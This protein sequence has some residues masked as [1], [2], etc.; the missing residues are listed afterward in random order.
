MP[1][2]S[3]TEALRAG[4]P[5]KWGSWCLAPHLLSKSHLSPQP[6]ARGV[7]DQ[8]SAPPRGASHVAGPERNAVGTFAHRN[9]VGHDERRGVDDR[10]RAIDDV[11]DE[12]VAAVA[13]DRDAMGAGT[14]PDC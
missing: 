6:V 10:D 13:A 12:H 14:R 5:L 7:A 1:G 8:R 9:G 4:G 3:M 11:A 2:R